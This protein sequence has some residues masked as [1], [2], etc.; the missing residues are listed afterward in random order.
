MKKKILMLFPQGIGDMIY[1]IDQFLLN[2]KSLNEEYDFV[3]IIQYKQNY[4]LL[5]NFIKT[6]NIKVYYTSKKFLDNLIL[7]KELFFKKFDYLVIDPN[8]NLFKALSFSLLINAKLKIFKYFVFCQ[9]FFNKVINIKNLSRHKMMFELSK[10]FDEKNELEYKYN[11]FNLKKYFIKKNEKKKII[12]IAPG[13]G[14]LEK[15]KRWPIEKFLNLINIIGKKNSLDE[16]YIFASPDEDHLVKYLTKNI[17][18]LKISIF[19]NKIIDSIKALNSCKVLIANDNGMV[20]AAHCLGINHITII[21]PS[22]P[23]QF[24]DKKLNNFVSLN[25]PCSPCYSRQRLGCGNEICLKQLDSQAV[26]N[27]FDEINKQNNFF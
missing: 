7:I 13:S 9:F 26:I 1:T 16:I 6:E 25:L 23:N 24:V 17:K 14:T 21:G 5:A 15:H 12:G 2:V 3:F 19:N 4:D 22:F 8:L 10:I 27:K 11:Q 18:N 20:H